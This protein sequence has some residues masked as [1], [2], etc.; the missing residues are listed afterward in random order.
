M[1]LFNACPA[2]TRDR[3]VYDLRSGMNITVP[4]V[5]T[6]SYQKSF[7]PLTISNWNDLKP[8]VRDVG[9]L[10]TFKEHLKKSSGFKTNKLFH[11]NSNKDAINHTRIRLGLSGLS[12]QRCDYRHIDNPRCVLCNAPKED[13]AHYFLTC[14]I[15]EEHRPEFLTG[16]CDI[17][18]ANNIEIEFRLRRFR[19]NFIKTILNGNPSFSFPENMSIFHMT[20]TF[21]KKSK[22]F[23]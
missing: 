13:P 7:F 10:N 16:I 12:S 8:A 9:T 17:Y 2:L 20:Q 6:T 22:R 4:P 3:T 15:H 14:P 1:Y 11:H 21:I 23:P 5:R 18:N 19:E